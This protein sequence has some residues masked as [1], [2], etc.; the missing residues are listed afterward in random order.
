MG[1]EQPYSRM[2][3]KLICAIREHFAAGREAEMPVLKPAEEACIRQYAA[4]ALYPEKPLFVEKS[5][6][7]EKE[8][9][10]E[11]LKRLLSFTQTFAGCT[12]V[13]RML[14]CGG[15]D[16]GKSTLIGR[17][18]YETMDDADKEKIRRDRRNLRP[19]QSVDY[20]VLAGAS[21]EELM[22][23]ITVE[24]SYHAFY[25]NG[26]GFL[27]ADV[28]GHEE[29]TKNMAA[30]AEGA[31][32]AVIMV[33]ADK[34]IVPQ[35]RRHTRICSFMGIRK[36]VFAVNKMDCVGYDRACFLQLEEE[37]RAMMQEYPAGSVCVVPVAAK[38]GENLVTLSGHLPWYQGKPL[39]D[40]ICETEDPQEKGKMSDTFCMPV[41]RICKKSQ[42]EGARIKNRVIQGTV[43]SGRIH[44]GDTV[45]IYP[46][47]QHAKVTRLYLPGQEGKEAAEESPVGIELDRELDVARGSTL[48]SAD[49]FTASDRLE[50][51]LLWMLEKRLTPGSR[52]ELLLGTRTVKVSVAKILYAVDTGTGEHHP[53]DYL[54]RNA[55]ARCELCLEEVTDVVSFR[56]NRRMGSFRLKKEGC[57]E[58]AAYGLIIKTVSGEVWDEEKQ[59][60]KRAERENTLGQHAGIICFPDRKG[61][62]DWMNFLERYLLELGFHTMQ[63]PLAGYVLSDS[64]VIRVLLDAGLL[65]FVRLPD[66]DRKQLREQFLDV[67]VLD[68][69]QLCEKEEDVG[70]VCREFRSR[71]GEF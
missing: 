50:A 29:Y 7:K 41:Q 8:T 60:V 2:E 17:L 42:M 51:D 27:I 38:A 30:A 32:L 15:V 71:I 22:Q 39:L 56:E 61:I 43:V 52:F 54:V 5:P 6:E 31:Q 68:F 26:N 11:Q 13:Q 34:G 28:P 47:G 40:T 18:L 45:Y 3:Q 66:G 20:A 59:P 44:P 14:V 69:G 64:G 55:M 19:D 53:V 21:E 9:E 12:K 65:V 70:A 25:R 58:P 63:L 67:P 4:L 24:A 1:E 23:G 62:G 33:A 16:D 48:A 46:G 36:F 10:K 37:I 35:T 57:D 49:F